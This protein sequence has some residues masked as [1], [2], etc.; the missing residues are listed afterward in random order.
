MNIPQTIQYANKVYHYEKRIDELEKARVYIENILKNLSPTP[1]YFKQAEGLQYRLVAKIVAI[2]YFDGGYLEEDYLALDAALKEGLGKMQET[3][4]PK[5][6]RIYKRILAAAKTIR[7]IVG[8]VGSLLATIQDARGHCIVEEPEKLSFVE[9]LFAAKIERLKVEVEDTADLFG[10]NVAMFDIKKRVVEELTGL[11]NWTVEERRKVDGRDMEAFM[12]HNFTALDKEGELTYVGYAEGLVTG[13]YSKAR[14]Y[15]IYSPLQDEITLF[16]KAFAAEHGLTFMQVNA[17][18]FEGKTTEFLDKTFS[19]LENER[20]NLL[21][22]SLK[23]YHGQ[24]KDEILQ[25]LLWYSQKGF[26]VF[27]VDLSG[28]RML[29][30]EFMQTTERVQGLSIL[31]V[32][33]QYLRMPAFGE[34]IEI[35]VEKDM[36]SRTESEFIRKNMPYMGYVGLNKCI[37][38]YTDGKPWRDC[39]L[40]YSNE[41]SGSLMEYLSNIPSQDQFISR[42]WVDLK[43]EERNNVVYGEFDYD[44]VHVVN[45]ENL[46]KIVQADINLFAKCGLVTRYCTLCGDDYSVWPT[47]DTKE[48]EKRLSVAT[49]LVA[50]LLTCLYAPEVKIIPEEEWTDKK[51]G[52]YCANAGK[53]IAYRDGCTLSYEWAVKAVCHECFHSFQHTVIE[54]GYKEWHFNSLGIS[55]S[56]APEWNRNFQKYV[57]IGRNYEQYMRQVVEAD[58]RIFE[59]DCFEQ[60]AG[61]WKL[62]DLE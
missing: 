53:L 26:Y 33:C 57:Q 3:E 13:E 42:D 52:G 10:T 4:Y 30:E 37:A 25:R 46:K 41:H 61:K 18:A 49:K 5:T 21:V 59:E 7:D 2:R 44:E 23:E 20:Q 34:L 22:H 11:Y 48:R 60:S 29:Y 43:L 56:R 62:F 24:N 54:T 14:T 16:T 28:E 32:S 36:I 45:P 40:R 58:A 35:L 31:D 15:V 9:N 50:H 38:L 17:Y 47:L 55:K 51:S 8:D 6:V 19:L 39:G 27:A 1:E 12:Q